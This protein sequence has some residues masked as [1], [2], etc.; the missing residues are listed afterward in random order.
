MAARGKPV[1]LRRVGCALS[2]PASVHQSRGLV[3]CPADDK[4]PDGKRWLGLS[5]ATNLAVLGTFKYYDFFATQAAELF[6]FFGLHL[7]PPLLSVVLPVGLSF[8]TFQAM[9]YTLDV[10]RRDA[11]PIR[12]LPH[13]LLYI[14]FFPHLVAGPI[15]R[16][17]DLPPQLERLP[18]ANSRQ[19]AEGALLILWGYVKKVVVADNLAPIVASAFDAK[20]PSAA[21]VI[22]GAYAFTWQI[23]CD[24]AGY[25]D[26]ARGVAKW[27]GVELMINFDLPFFAHSPRELW[28]RWHRSLSQWLRD[29]LYIP[30]GGNRRHAQRNLILTMLLGGLWHGANWTFVAWGAWHG[31]ALAI[32]RSFEARFPR[33]RLPAA[34]AVPL[35]FH[36]TMLAFVLF[37]AH[38]LGQVR[39]L[40]STALNWTGLGAT[41]SAHLHL[42]ALLVPPVLLMEFLLWRTGGQVRFPGVLPRPV[43]GAFAA[44]AT[45][46][47]VL[48]GATYGQQFIYFQF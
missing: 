14:S 31:F 2:R 41:E 23:Y 1:L 25:S 30:L 39:E 5:I 21:A 45:L 48:F 13:F 24:F 47:L 18:G 38:N 34:L 10:Y 26:I 42:F 15:Q 3:Q 36:F 37:R 35:T 9:G 8:Y 7:S 33:F 43:Q 32:Q 19:W 44:L 6:A 29:Y 28:R 22:L 17:Q 12:K 40:A 4:G 27:L 16:T 20:S 46:T 11:Q